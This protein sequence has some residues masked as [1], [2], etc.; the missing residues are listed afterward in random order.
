[1]PPAR[2]KVNA[3]PAAQ[4]GGGAVEIGLVQPGE[5][6]AVARLHAGTITGGFLVKLGPRFLASLYRGIAADDQSLVLVARDGGRVIGFC[7]YTDNVAGLYR[8]VLR[9][10]ALGLALG[11]L[12]RALDPRILKEV[13]D[14]LRYPQKQAT[15]D[16]PASELLTLGV[17]GSQ[18]G[19]GVGRQL[20]EACIEKARERGQQRVKVLAGA[21]LEPANKLYRS[22]GFDL[23]T[24]ISQH[25]EPLNVLVRDLR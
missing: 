22:L 16:L 10:R 11:A 18:R 21:E 8:R 20:V 4:P 3:V 14:T 13:L 7:A 23:A 17:D 12:P 24:Q 2:D 5:A 19:R 1:M 25:G 6:A 9:R 15:G